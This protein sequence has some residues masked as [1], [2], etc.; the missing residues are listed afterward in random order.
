MIEPGAARRRW[1]AAAAFPGVESDVT[2]IAAGGNKGRLRPPALHQ[3]EAKHA[4]IKGKRAI[5]IGDLKMDMADATPGSMEGALIQLAFAV[6]LRLS[7][8]TRNAVMRL[9][10]LRST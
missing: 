3:L 10:V 5:D 9:R 6:G 2:V 8:A 4:A 7:G 1:I